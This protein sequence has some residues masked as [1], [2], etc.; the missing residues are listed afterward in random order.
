MSADVVE[1][2]NDNL[3]ASIESE[4]LHLSPFLQNCL[5]FLHRR[6]GVVLGVDLLMEQTPLFWGWSPGQLEPV[7]IIVTIDPP[8]IDWLRS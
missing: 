7:R 6:L 2:K 3:A 5:A 1:A 4:P 8:G